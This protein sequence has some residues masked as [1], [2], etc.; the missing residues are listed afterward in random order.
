MSENRIRHQPLVLAALFEKRDGD[1]LWICGVKGCGQQ[2]GIVA[3]AHIS[4][5]W[6]KTLQQWIVTEHE[7]RVVLKPE[8]A[9]RADGVWIQSKRH[10]FRAGRDF[11]VTRA[12]EAGEEAVFL[13]S[14]QAEIKQVER[15]LQE[16]LKLL[17][18]N[19][20]LS[21]DLPTIVQCPC[22]KCRRLS[23]IPSVKGIAT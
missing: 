19:V 18:Y 21:K 6:S 4:K 9:K 12:K 20:L 14:A 16:G 1:S 15:V 23:R 8:M 3:P 11:N 22:L 17:S 2:L 7:A 5:Q 13:F 10:P